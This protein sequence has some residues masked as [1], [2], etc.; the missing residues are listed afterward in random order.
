MSI[1][2]ERPSMTM[3]DSN[4]VLVCGAISS[5]L[6]LIRFFSTRADAVSKGE[7]ESCA[8][9]SRVANLLRSMGCTNTRLSLPSNSLSMI[10]KPDR[11]LLRNEEGV[12]VEEVCPFRFCPVRP[13]MCIRL[14]SALAVS[15]GV[16]VLGMPFGLP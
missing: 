3:F 12:I 14:K 7:F 16:L 15:S 2:R 1:S 4:P 8:T 10:S 6:P 5:I 11:L 9:S 13:T